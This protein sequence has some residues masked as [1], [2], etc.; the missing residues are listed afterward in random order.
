MKNKPERI[1]E[2][3]QKIGLDLSL[4]ESLG[5]HVKSNVHNAFLE[6]LFNIYLNSLPAPKKEGEEV[7]DSY[8]HT[9]KDKKRETLK[10]KIVITNDK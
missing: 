7:V 4:L 5:V 2:F 3:I 8:E 6:A 1:S 10:E 9:D